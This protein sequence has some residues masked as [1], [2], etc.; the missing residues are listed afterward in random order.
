MSAPFRVKYC[1]YI[2]KARI[3]CLICLKTLQTEILYTKWFDLF[4]SNSNMCAKKR[5]GG[6]VAEGAPLLREYGL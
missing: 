2:L 1:P 6:R 3:I 4:S 5:R